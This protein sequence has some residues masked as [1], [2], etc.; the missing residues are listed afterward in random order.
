MKIIICGKSG[1]GKD[2]LRKRMS[3]L[4]FNY[5]K[6]YTTRPKREQENQD[7]YQYIDKESFL[8]L[9]EQNFF[10]DFNA[11][12]G[13]FYGLSHDDWQNCNL[14]VMTPKSINGLAKEEINKILIIYLD[15]E[16]SVRRKRIENRS[17]SSDS[18]ERRINADNL[19]FF[20]FS[21]YNLHIKNLDF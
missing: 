17:D 8:K 21:S 6:P 4:G 12:N 16:E 5:A 9:V 3:T 20:N 7:D 11:Y 19:D 14:F 18:I 10:F 15:I 13:W 1:S 2:F